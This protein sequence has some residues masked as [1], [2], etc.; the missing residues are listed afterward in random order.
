MHNAT[1]FAKLFELTR[2]P[3][4]KTHAKCQQQIRVIDGVIGVNRP[5]HPQH[6]QRL[7]I[8]LRKNTQPHQRLCHGNARLAGKLAKLFRRIRSHDT[9]TGINKWA[10]GF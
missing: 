7:W 9:P 4:I 10:F 6:L 5:V 3:I 8:S 1:V 2:H